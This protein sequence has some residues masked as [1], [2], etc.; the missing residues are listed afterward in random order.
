MK[1]DSATTNQSNKHAKQLIFLPCNRGIFGEFL[2]P[3]CLLSMAKPNEIT[4]VN[5][6]EPSLFL[7]KTASMALSSLCYI[8]QRLCISAR[9]SVLGACDFGDYGSLSPHGPVEQIQVLY[10]WNY[11]CA[12]T[13]PYTVGQ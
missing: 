10:T 7:T 6:R 8:A 1:S 13:V 5:Q 3:I 9:L 4:S 12:Y 11:I 2:C